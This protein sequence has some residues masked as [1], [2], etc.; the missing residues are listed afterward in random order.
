MNQEQKSEIIID[1]TVINQVSVHV[2][3]TG[4][5]DLRWNVFDLAV[6]HRRMAMMKPPINHFTNLKGSYFGDIAPAVVND[7]INEMFDNDPAM[8][9]Q[10]FALGREFEQTDY[11]ETINIHLA[12]FEHFG[13]Q[14]SYCKPFIFE[15]EVITK[16]FEKAKN[17]LASANNASTPP[18]GKVYPVVDT[19]LFQCISVEVSGPAEALSGMGGFLEGSV[20]D[21]RINPFNDYS[22]KAARK[23]IDRVKSDKVVVPIDRVYIPVSTLKKITALLIDAFNIDPMESKRKS[24]LRQAC[25]EQ[26]AEY[27]IN[28][29]IGVYAY[30]GPNAQYTKDFIA[31]L[32]MIIKAYQIIAGEQFDIEKIVPVVPSP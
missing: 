20:V 2:V 9:V 5:V 14:A 3:Q 21:M 12:I 6:E 1:P 15:H 23:F 30:F 13:P 28:V 11:E 16:A 18:E 19:N 29:Y 25:D 22:L 4:H 24:Q 7:I 10:C 32:E 8:A 27:F 26:N 31:D 17:M